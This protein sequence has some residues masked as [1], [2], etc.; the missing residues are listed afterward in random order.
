M[1][2]FDN[3]ERVG[4]VVQNARFV[5]YLNWL[6]FCAVTFRRFFFPIKVIY[7]DGVFKQMTTMKTTA[8]NS[9]HET[10]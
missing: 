6:Y 10:Y 8:N 5:C 4:I 2:S 3:D 1:Y 9:D 7:F